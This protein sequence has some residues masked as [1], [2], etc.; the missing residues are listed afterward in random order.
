MTPQLY[1]ILGVGLLLVVDAVILLWINNRVRDTTPDLKPLNDGIA[2]IAEEVFRARGR[3][4]ALQVDQ[5][6]LAK[7][8]TELHKFVTAPKPEAPK[9]KPIMARNWREVQTLVGTGEYDAS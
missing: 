7:S 5:N 1:A 3:F 2:A 8:I 4:D 9:N 6:S